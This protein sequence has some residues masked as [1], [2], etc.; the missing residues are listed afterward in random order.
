[1]FSNTVSYGVADASGALVRRE[2]FEAPYCSMIHDFMVTENHVLIPVL[3]LTGDLQR[4]MRGGPAFAW[5]PEKPAMVAVMTRAGG[6][7]SLR[8]FSTEAAYVF[9]PMNA[10]EEDGKIFADVM[11][12]DAAPLFPLADGSAGRPS[13][14]YLVRWIF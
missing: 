10:W 8:W 1:P 6:V 14:A 7:A 9:H 11:R 4:V 2:D 3:P 5:E 12:Y 13:A